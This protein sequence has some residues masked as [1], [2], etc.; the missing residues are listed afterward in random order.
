MDIVVRLFNSELNVDSGSYFKVLQFFFPPSGEGRGPD[1]NLNNVKFKAF[2][3]CLSLKALFF[4]Y[5]YSKVKKNKQT[6]IF[7]YIIFFFQIF[8]KKKTKTLKV[9]RY[10]LTRYP[11]LTDIRC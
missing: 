1:V 11:V 5:A 10:P 2:F 3:C 7:V 6:R 4:S 8:L 9:R